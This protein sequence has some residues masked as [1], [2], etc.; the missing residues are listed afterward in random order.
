MTP[1]PSTTS[2]WLFSARTDLLAFAFPAALALGAI[3][4]VPQLRE[5]TESSTWLWVVGVLLV[6]VAHVWSTMFVSYFS[7]RQLRQN[8]KRYWLVP[9]LSWAMGTAVYAWGGASLFWTTLAYLAV[10]HFVR[11]QY[12]WLALYR[13]RSGEGTKGLLIDRAAIY[14]ATLYP[15]VWWH[16]HLPRHFVWFLPGDFK[17]GVSPWVADV[18]LPFYVFFLGAYFVQAVI[19]YSQSR[20]LCWGKHLLILCTAATWYVGIVATNSDTAFT[21]TNV[22]THGIPYAVLVFHYARHLRQKSDGGLSEK[23]LS[24]HWASALCRFLLCIWAFAYLE[25]L[26]WDRVVWFERTSLFGTLGASSAQPGRLW[27]SFAVPLLAVPQLTHYALDGLLWRR[28]NNPDLGIWFRTL[29]G[30]RQQVPSN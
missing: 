23:L 7:P 4:V 11:Q 22:F 30:T 2:P 27:Q 17:S 29:P 26:L 10:L 14:A 16:A 6:D 15:L 1:S 8:A 25:E 18:C 24:G 13:A 3:F 9:T 28:R 12:G 21:I 20:T 19:Q 5:P